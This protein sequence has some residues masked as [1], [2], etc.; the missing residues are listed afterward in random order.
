VPPALPFRLAWP[1][2]AADRFTS[3]MADTPF[4]GFLPPAW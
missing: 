1:S 3:L 4:A 2:T